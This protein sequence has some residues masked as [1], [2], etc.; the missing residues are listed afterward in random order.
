MLYAL[1]ARLTMVAFFELR[2]LGS[3]VVRI[4]LRKKLLIRNTFRIMI[5]IK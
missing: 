5:L 3:A 4:V 1:M 2:G